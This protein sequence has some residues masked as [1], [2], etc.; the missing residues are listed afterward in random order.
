MSP[1]GE[2]TRVGDEEAALRERAQK[3][4]QGAG[5]LPET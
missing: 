3:A 5:L 4:L 1:D 2:R